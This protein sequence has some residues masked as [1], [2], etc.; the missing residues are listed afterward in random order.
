MA[1]S[2]D[3]PEAQP[4]SDAHPEQERPQE[5]A[6]TVAHGARAVTP[7]PEVEAA[8][9]AESERRILDGLAS[10]RSLATNL[11]SRFGHQPPPRLTRATTKPTIGVSPEAV[12]RVERRSDADATSWYWWRRVTPD[13]SMLQRERARQVAAQ[14]ARAALNRTR[15]ARAAAEAARQAALASQELSAEMAGDSVAGELSAHAEA[16]TPAVAVLEPSRTDSLTEVEAAAAVTVSPAPTPGGPEAHPV[17]EP[18]SASQGAG[19]TATS[20][21]PTTPGGPPDTDAPA[22][23]A[24]SPATALPEQ[25]PQPQLGGTP[26]ADM[27][28][29]AAES[30]GTVVGQ[31]VRQGW[32]A[33]STVFAPRE[34][35]P[36]SRRTPHPEPAPLQLPVSAATAAVEPGVPEARTTTTAPSESVPA[37]AEPAAGLTAPSR[38]AEQGTTTPPSEASSGAVAQD[39]ALPQPPAA[40]SSAPAPEADELSPP[41]RSTAAA[42]EPGGD[43]TADS[44]PAAPIDAAS[45]E[46][47]AQV[48]Q[49]ATVASAA[50]ASSAA[51]PQAEVA[52]PRETPDDLAP[53]RAAPQDF[54]RD[55][56]SATTSAAP[57]GEDEASAGPLDFGMLDVVDPASAVAPL[58]YQ[59]T[60]RYQAASV[61]TVASNAPVGQSPS[62]L[63]WWPSLDGGNPR[64]APRPEQ[65]NVVRA[66]TQPIVAPERVRPRPEPVV[67]PAAE[68]TPT[69]PSALAGAFRREPSA[70]DL[71][72]PLTEGGSRFEG[73]YVSRR[74][75][76]RPVNAPPERSPG[77]VAPPPRAMRPA[78]PPEAP[79]LPPPTEPGLVGRWQHVLYIAESR[80]QRRNAITSHLYEM[81]RW[82]QTRGANPN[83]MRIRIEA[84]LPLAEQPEL[85]FAAQDLVLAP[86]PGVDAPP[87][88]DAH[89]AVP[90]VA[91]TASPSLVPQLDAPQGPPAAA[92]P[93]VPG[94][95][96]S[97]GGD[98]GG[99]A[100]P[101]TP[102]VQP[103]VAEREVPTAVVSAQEVAAV[104]SSAPTMVPAPPVDGGGLGG[105]FRR[106]VGRPQIP[107]PPPGR[108]NQ[109]SQP[110][111]PVPPAPDAGTT[112][113]ASTPGAPAAQAQAAAPP[114]QAAPGVAPAIPPTESGT[115]SQAVPAAGGASPTAVA[116]DEPFRS[117][118]PSVVLAP[119]SPTALA[120]HAPR[121]SSD[122]HPVGVPLAPHLPPRPNERSAAG[123]ASPA[124]ASAP[125]DGAPLPAVGTGPDGTPV[126]STEA[127]L[128][129]HLPPSASPPASQ[130]V[131]GQVETPSTA[132]AAGASGVAPQSAVGAVQTSAPGYPA[133]P[134][135]VLAPG[136]NP[137]GAGQQRASSA[138][139]AS[140]STAAPVQ[141]RAEPAPTSEP[142]TAPAAAPAHTV[143]LSSSPAV[144]PPVQIRT[145]DT[146]PRLAPAAPGGQDAATE[147]GRPSAPQGSQQQQMTGLPQAGSEA[148]SGLVAPLE[149]PAPNVPAAAAGPAVGSPASAQAQPA[150]STSATPSDQPTGSS[151]QPLTPTSPGGAPTVSG[152]VAPAPT[153]GTPAG[154]PAVPSTG[155]SGPLQVVIAQDAPARA[156]SDAPA[157]VAAPPGDQAGLGVWLRRLLGRGQASQP[158]GPA[159]PQTTGVSAQGNTPGA[160]VG[161]HGA[162]PQGATASP[163][164]GQ[165]SVPERTAPTPTAESSVTNAAASPAAAQ[166]GAGEAAI[167][168]EL[169]ASAT[170]P[171]AADLPSTAQPAP[172]ADQP[173]QRL[174]AARV[175]PAE[176][177]SSTEAGPGV[178]Q[179]MLAALAQAGHPEGHEVVVHGDHL[180]VVVVPPAVGAAPAPVDTVMA[181]G[182][183]HAMRQGETSPAATVPSHVEAHGQPRVSETMPGAP[184]ASAFAAQPITQVQAAPATPAT[185]QQSMEQPLPVVR[186]E[187]APPSEFAAVPRTVNAPVPGRPRA[188]DG[189]TA[190]GPSVR[191]AAPADSAGA[192]HADLAARLPARPWEATDEQLA[193]IVSRLPSAMAAQMVAAG[194]LGPDRRLPPRATAAPDVP[195]AL[196][197]A[198]PRAEPSPWAAPE[199][200]ASGRPALPGAI[201]TGVLAPVPMVRRPSAATSTSLFG[202]PAYTGG[203]VENASGFSF[204]TGDPTIAS[205][206]NSLFAGDGAMTRS[207]MGVSSGRAGVS[208]APIQ[209]ESGVETASAPL[210]AQ[211]PEPAPGNA[212]ED[213]DKLAEQVFELLRWRLSAELERTQGWS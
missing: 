85:D 61:P 159:A 83:D 208:R 142:A 138:P 183:P 102:D 68:S 41:V 73:T 60:K 82:S 143:P 181:P 179:A 198:A 155:T 80:Q 63:F 184:H 109:A 58:S 186:E 202:P 37:T 122:V 107:T 105:W 144:E 42:G 27:P 129:E 133:T 2:A 31:W 153:H 116:A 149:A 71:P 65:P 59:L 197:D 210:S 148:G 178:S 117:S 97:P 111:S 124:S 96:M 7:T 152:A 113:G 92:G 180:D 95:P 172:S 52:A 93:A 36:T 134:T 189:Q 196:A 104:P 90:Q 24:F 130:M 54:V 78:Q 114:S 157:M 209:R 45:V 150:A 101:S 139:S 99:T 48:P 39:P 10:R 207:S 69:L 46:S 145:D 74:R 86:Q 28:A 11:A 167:A 77:A 18:V 49:S 146:A 203:Q 115:S 13:M 25:V 212:Q 205:D 5:A 125:S 15:A 88:Q 33:L 213:L 131:A 108:P 201:G 76:P 175:A 193:D 147:A 47:P 200:I 26:P 164:G 21:A 84:V 166:S 72:P 123:E 156:G 141:R 211:H 43:K 32:Q 81:D 89:P 75:P 154:Q 23:L 118:A 194:V 1:E 168:H 162:L 100:A 22:P 91:D 79:P 16:A 53:A 199:S 132:Q 57:A 62:R 50:V 35:L 19:A 160:P 3:D 6:P 120:P 30:G 67:A 55:A 51:A 126:G 110:A 188:T 127:S 204:S 135:Q 177:G 190:N 40:A 34:G 176:A 121:T 128:T 174:Q 98:A 187:T 163:A 171:V 70:P 8:T 9:P 94:A 12:A 38:L 64:R 103:A 192:P 106:L 87:S 206:A 140:T 17:L 195:Q 191:P 112:S 14:H 20:A 56:E 169:T 136:N 151:T 66:Y 165:P 119:T 137:Q 4:V 185:F 44:G 158:S 170:P 161:E 29:P 173:T 182:Q